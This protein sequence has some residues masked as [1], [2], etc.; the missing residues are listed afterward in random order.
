MNQ[1]CYR[2]PESKHCR[3]TLQYADDIFRP[4]TCVSTVAVN[5]SPTQTRLHISIIFLFCP[6]CKCIQMPP[7]EEFICVTKG[8]PFRANHKALPGS[9]IFHDCSQI[10]VNLYR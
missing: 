10:A 9:T 2:F 4:G 3:R 8:R 6:N 5:E 1:K 7:T